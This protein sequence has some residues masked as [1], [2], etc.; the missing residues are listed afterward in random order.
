MVQ[1]D[2]TI[3]IKIKRSV[4]TLSWAC[5][6]RW[7]KANSTEFIGAV[8][9]MDRIEDGACFCLEV[10]AVRYLLFKEDVVLQVVLGLLLVYADWKG[11]YVSEC[12]CKCFMT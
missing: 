12:V 1:V 4:V 5:G 6:R 11:A 2:V 8:A 9:V 10:I 7:R 3:K